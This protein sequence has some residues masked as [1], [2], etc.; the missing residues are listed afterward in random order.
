LAAQQELAV[1]QATTLPG[2]NKGQVLAL[3]P[4]GQFLAVAGMNGSLEVWSTAKLPRPMASR[5][6]ERLPSLK[7]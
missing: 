3:S 5:E 2:L 4:R 6:R 1:V 7:R